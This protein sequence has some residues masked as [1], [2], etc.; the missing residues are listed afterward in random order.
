MRY[1]RELLDAFAF[2]C[3]IATPFIIYFW[4]MK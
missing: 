3:V 2:A 1:I 4:S